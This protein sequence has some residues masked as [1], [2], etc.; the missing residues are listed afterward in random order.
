M[1]SDAAL[2]IFLW[3]EFGGNGLMR[4]S[5]GVGWRG[6]EKGDSRKQRIDGRAWAEVLN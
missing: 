5:R 2:K 1:Y 4:R 6:G 3:V